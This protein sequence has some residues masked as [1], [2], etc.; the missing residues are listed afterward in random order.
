MSTPDDSTPATSPRKV[1]I[2]SSLGPAIITASVV[3]GPGSIVSASKLGNTY[4]FS[5]TW[6]VLLAVVLMICMTAL[7]ARLGV[8]LEKSLC[9]ELKV[10]AGRPLAILAGVSVFL[11]CACFQYSNNLGILLAVEPLMENVS[12]TFSI[13]VIVAL[14]VF[15]IAVLWGLKSLYGHIETLMK[16]LVAMMT[17]AFAINLGCALLIPAEEAPAEAAVAAAEVVAETPAPSPITLV[18]IIAM[19]ATT[20]SVAGAFYQSYLVREKGWTIAN[21]RQGFVDSTLGITVLGLITL[22]VMSTSAIVLHG[23]AGIEL[24]SAADVALALEPA[25]GKFAVIIF[26]LGIFAGAFSSFL[27]NSMIGGAM[28]SDGF[29]LGY[30]IDKTWPKVFTTIALLT[31][32]SVAVYVKSQD[33]PKPANLIVFAQSVTVIANPV[34]AAALL[35]LA[36]RKDLIGNRKI[37]TWLKIMA[38]I[39][40]IVAIGFAYRTLSGLLGS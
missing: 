5:M 18:T 26:C 32:M 30:H 31:G 11:I 27:V 38:V 16:I 12:P 15:I 34:L 36:T 14:N 9:E 6:V 29:G 24:N 17:I 39:G 13:S 1:S 2:L 33:L 10:R 23:K 3:L 7:S 28:L 4:G 19:F 25:F 22:M 37:P 8:V 20:F 40:L 21:I 35:W